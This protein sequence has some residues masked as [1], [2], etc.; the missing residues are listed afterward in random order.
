M[1]GES[2]P[3]GIAYGHLH[4]EPTILIVPEGRNRDLVADMCAEFAPALLRH[5]RAPAY[6]VDEPTSWGD[7]DPLRQIWLPN[8]SH[9]D[10]LHHLAYAYTFTRWGAGARGRLN[11]LGR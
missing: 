4:S 11:A 2:R 3:W 10:M 1:G 6:L 8:G 7:L 5:L 9:L